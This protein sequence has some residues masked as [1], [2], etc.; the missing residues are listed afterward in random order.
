MT[1]TKLHAQNSFFD[2]DNDFYDIEGFKSGKNT[3]KFIEL[4]ELG[5]VKNKSLLQLN[6]NFGLE[7]LSWARL[8]A[9]V[10]GIDYNFKSIFLANLLSKTT[11]IPATFISTH[12][13]DLS[14]FQIP[15]KDIVYTSYGALLLVDDLNLLANQVS[16]ILKPGGVFFVVEFHPILLTLNRNLN[17]FS[18]EDSDSEERSGYFNNHSLSEIF[19]VLNQNGFNIVKFIE[20]PYSVYN[21]FPG[22][23][24]IGEDKW[25]FPSI[26]SNLPYMYSLKAVK[27]S[28]SDN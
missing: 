11:D 6:C 15:P 18:V 9:E 17:G 5:D 21:S 23:Q 27:K 13:K 26:K 4:D 3:L 7:T 22:M 8:G 2:S 20:Y 24:Q 14:N 25:V 1:A 10:T 19:T 12:I 28:N 16:K